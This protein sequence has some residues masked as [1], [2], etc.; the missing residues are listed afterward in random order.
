M[1]VVAE[2]GHDV[3]TI[4]GALHARVKAATGVSPDRVVFERDPD[5]L[6]RRLF[7]TPSM[8]AQYVEERRSHRQ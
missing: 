7:A 3:T 8:K 1:T 4:E 6:D 2:G 5:V